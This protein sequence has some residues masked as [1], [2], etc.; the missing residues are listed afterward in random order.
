MME[1]DFK[2]THSFEGSTYYSGNIDIG[3]SAHYC[4]K[5]AIFTDYISVSFEY[6]NRLATDKEDWNGY[7]LTRNFMGTKKENIDKA[8]EWLNYLLSYPPESYFETKG[9]AY[10]RLI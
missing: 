7:R 5:Y 8:K 10:E 1:F 9:V 4:G 2:K 6:Q 3:R